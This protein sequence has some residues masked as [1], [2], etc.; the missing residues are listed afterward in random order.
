MII[1][2]ASFTA[3][4][5][6]A[7]LI[8]GFSGSILAP[9]RLDDRLDRL[10]GETGTSSD[11]QH[12]DTLLKKYRRETQGVFRSSWDA[13]NY[14]LAGYSTRAAVRAFITKQWVL[15]LGTALLLLGFGWANRWSGATILVLLFV[16]G[17]CGLVI[18]PRLWIKHQAKR[19]LR[20][21]RIY[22]ADTIDLL[23]ICLEAGL[24]FD[25]A[26]QR[27]AKEQQTAS[28]FLSKEFLRTNQEILAGVS[29]QNALRSMC[30]RC[31][32]QP[33]LK[34]LVAIIV[35]AER[36]G[37][38]IAKSLR[39]MAESL[40]FK[41]RQRAQEIVNKLPVRLAFPLVFCIF[42][43]MLVV[44]MGPAVIQLFHFFA[45]G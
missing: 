34:S 45:G 44:L 4:A 32:N 22:L 27:V 39:T 7:C 42:P 38:S 24:G 23:I 6:V 5:S 30:E 18:F 26:L 11:R 14:Y 31:G 2:L 37:A 25:A 13:H 10:V 17:V 28:P 3:G 20:E 35:Q 16:T 1:W 9:R 19:R 21:I 41:R 15:T 36:L 40:R 29:R 12:G 8:L 43:A 33:D